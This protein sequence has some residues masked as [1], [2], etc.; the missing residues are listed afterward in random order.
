[1]KYLPD[2]GVHSRAFTMENPL[3]EPGGGGKANGGRK[4]LPALVPFPAG[5]T[6]TLAEIEGSGVV[7]H[8][9]ITTPPGNPAV[10]RNLILRA[11]WNHSKTPAVECPLPDFFGNAHGIRR[12]LNSALLTVAEGRGFNAWFAMPF[13]SGAKLTLENANTGDVSHLF[14]QVDATV[15]DLW[16]EGESAYFHAQFRRENPTRLREDYQVVDIPEGRGRFL[17]VTLGVRTLEKHW[18]GEGEVKFYLDGDRDFPTLCGTGLEDY[19]GSAWG[20]GEFGSAFLG[21]PL[22]Q[23]GENGIGT[24]VSL[25]RFHQED[26]LWFHRSF[27]MTVQQI[28][29]AFAK[30]DAERIRDGSLSLTEPLKDGQGFALF[31]R[32]DDLC[33]TAYF[34]LNRAEIPCPPFPDFAARS[35][36]LGVSLST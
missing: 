8:L 21:C 12:P 30:D 11:Y 33:S 34:Y 26:P 20:I 25:Y 1:M 22:Y 9:W 18:W 7:R 10:D 32:E 28:G 23:N 15:G 16:R 13:R 17:G 27:Q 4:G 2:P 14:Y 36:N 3:G 6:H 29:G 5:A 35:A 24:R 31:E 19:F